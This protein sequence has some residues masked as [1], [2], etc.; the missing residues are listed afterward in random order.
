[1]RS[2]KILNQAVFAK[3]GEQFSPVTLP[4]T[5][6]ALDGQDGGNDYW[7]GTGTYEIQLPDPTPGKRQYIE[8]RGANH[9]ATVFCNGQEL[10]GHEG[11]FST[12]RFE[13]T[14]SLQPTDN[15]L[16]VLVSNAISHVYPQ[17]ADFTFFGGLYRDVAFI[18]VEDAHF[19]LMK[20]GSD[21]LFISAYSG[22][23]TRADVF[24]VNAE[25][26]DIQL[27]LLD[28]EDQVVYDN[29][30]PAQPHTYFNTVLA[31]AH[32]W[33]GMEDPY[34]YR[35]RA[36]LY[37]DGELLD[38]VTVTYGY[39]TC[40]IDA[41]QGFFLNG[42]ST[43]LHGV[44]RHQDRENKG[45][46]ISKEDHREDAELIR[47]V[48]ANTI[49]LAHYQH[50]QYFYDLCDHMGFVL[51]AEIPYISSHMP[52]QAS[53][54]NTI[55]QMTELIAQCYNHPSIMV[56]GIA[57]EITIGG[58]CEEQYRNL[59]DLNALVKRLDPSRLTTMAQLSR[60]PITDQQT[61][62]TDVQS[63]NIYY[64]W[65]VDTVEDS[66]P[67]MDK[68]H[69]MHPDRAYGISEYGAENIIK[70]HSAS[71]FCHDYTE[72]YASHYHHEMLKLFAQRPY[73][74]ATHVWNMFDFAADPRNEGGV[75]GR[76]N[77]GLVTFDRKTKKDAF[78]IYKA[79]WTKEPM[80]HIASRRFAHRAPGERDV[81]VY[82]NCDEVTL[83]L[84]GKA[85]ETVKAVD[86]ACVFHDV[87][88]ADGE[89]TLTAT[90]ENVSDTITLYGVAEHNEIYDYTD[91][92]SAVQAGNWFKEDDDD[93]KDYG[94]DGYSIQMPWK[95]LLVDSRCVNVL[96]GWGMSR[97]NADMPRRLR[98]VI[99]LGKWAQDPNNRNKTVRQMNIAPALSE[100]DFA[101]LDKLLHG[102]KR[103][104]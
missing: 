54:D 61:H 64:G 7:R 79:Y 91:L 80:V 5:W 84:N 51:W 85:L 37:K 18:E 55:S 98:F 48:G 88:L 43:P 75:E 33:Q 68:F 30:Q 24:P 83:N 13:L 10:G 87:P 57:N 35:A 65:Y 22:G 74:W 52:G 23:I 89:N 29:T 42:I 77:K 11:G 76:N 12:F 21:A 26:C 2:Y 3:D 28:A 63:Y 38:Q 1:M 86:H 78:F 19:D 92:L 58:I 9:I 59:C 81:I 16:R 100:E 53:H 90:A 62:I 40:R 17:H 66:G 70:W 47:E 82:T 73:L 71:P 39:R 72:E 102:I 56:W 49:R 8:I 25:G 95:D 104:Q 15:V 34:C 14:E 94:E 101:L 46:A 45:W 32:L 99:G 60:L 31:N 50:D 67:V 36:S 97:Q 20:H 69:A 41:E 103:E 4:H 93:A 96:K 44:C 6:N 27:E